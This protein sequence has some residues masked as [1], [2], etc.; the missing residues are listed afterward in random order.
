MPAGFF[1]TDAYL[2]W[3]K[4]NLSHLARFKSVFQMPYTPRAVRGRIDF[5]YVE[6]AGRDCSLP[7]LVHHVP[8][9]RAGDP[10]LL[11]PAHRRRGL[12]VSSAPPRLYLDERQRSS[13]PRDQVDFPHRRPKLP[14]ENRV[15]F[16]FEVRGGDFLAPIANPFR[17]H[18]IGLF[19][20]P[21]FVSMR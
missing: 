18:G 5:R 21:A 4:N 8:H 2:I 14:F 17:I 13:V 9:R 20:A 7:L 11:I 19:L 6:A 16:L 12:S 3:K 10:A 1:P 15:P